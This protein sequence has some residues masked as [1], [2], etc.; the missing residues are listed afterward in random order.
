ME[1]WKI[2]LEVIVSEYRSV[3]DKIRSLGLELTIC[4]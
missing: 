3:K 2:K 4:N 1:R